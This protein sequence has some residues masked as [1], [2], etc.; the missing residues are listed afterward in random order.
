MTTNKSETRLSNPLNLISKIASMIVILV[1][2]VVFVGW[3]FD[4]I[5]LK[6]V[7]PGFVT[8]KANTAIGFLFAGIALWLLND[9]Q[10]SQQWRIAADIF[11][12]IVT[13]L[14]G[15]TL[16]QYI[17]GLDFGIDQLFF[18]EASGAIGTS[19]PGRMAPNTALSFIFIGIALFLMNKKTVRLFLFSHF[20]VLTAVLITWTAL[21][22]YFYGIEESYGIPGYTRMALHTSLTFIVLS[23]GILFTRTNRGLIAVLI[24]ENTGSILMRRLLLAA[25]LLPVI[26][27]W[28]RWKGEIEGIYSTAV[29]M[30][31][32]VLATTVVLSITI[33]WVAVAF[34]RADKER[35]RA[36]EEL[37]KNRDQLEDIV[38]E[39]TSELSDAYSKMININ[40]ALKTLSECN[41]I[42]V[43]SK[44]EKELLDEICKVIVE[45]G[46]Y[47]MAW[48]GFA[49]NDE[50]KSVRVAAKAGFEKGYLEKINVTWKDTERGRGPTGTAIRTGKTVHVQDITNNE[51]FRPWRDIAIKHG[52]ASSIALPL[53][54]NG[55]IGGALSIYSKEP[56]AFNEDE[57]KLLE[58]LAM[59]LAYGIKALCAKIEKEKAVQQLAESEIKQHIIVKSI[60]DTLITIN[61]NGVIQSVNERGKEMFGYSAEELI[62]QP[63]ELLIPD[64]FREVHHKHRDKYQLDPKMREMGADLDLYAKRRNGTEFPVDVSLSPFSINQDHFVLCVVRDVTERKRLETRERNQS[65]IL[66]LI[67]KGTPLPA[68]LELIVKSIEQEDPSWL[69]SI[70]LL[71][72]EG[73]HLLHGAAPSLPDFYNQAI[74]GLAIGDGVGSCG[75]AAYAKKQVIVEDIFIHPYWIPFREL[76]QKANLHSCWSEPIIST[77]GKVLGT[78]AI[79]HREPKSPTQED[80]QRINFAAYFASI[81]IERKQTEEELIKAKEKAEEMNKLKSYFLSNM[82]HELR[83]PLISVLG[84]AEFLQSELTNPE[85]IE[86]ASQIMEGGKRLNQTLNSLLEFSKLEAESETAPLMPHNLADEVL[87]SVEPFKTAAKKKGIH[88]EAKI[89]DDKLSANINSELFQKALFHLITNAIKFTKAGSIT[90]ELSLAYDENKHWAVVKVIDTGIGIPEKLYD[91]LFAG[92][93]QASEGFSRYYEGVGLGLPLTNKIVNLLNGKISVK[94]KVGKGSEFSIWLPAIPDKKELIQEVKV[95]SDAL[96]EE[97]LSIKK[98][99]PAILLVEDNESNRMVIQ[100]FLKDRYDITEAVDGIFAITLAAKMKFDMILVDINLGE[101]VN[102]V[103]TMRQMRKIPGYVQIPIIAV[104]AY[105]MAGDSERFLREG[106]DGYITKPFSKKNLLEII[107]LKIGQAN[108]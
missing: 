101:G 33:L 46:G 4:I 98:T 7:Y 51:S 32:M 18:K 39:R 20:F 41:Q 29:G 25:I 100:L 55:G 47:R 60:P 16:C 83:T 21:L 79:Y 93:R 13:L 96:I 15:L 12:M 52:Y 64:R 48:I 63:I 3:I 81:A 108:K 104:T 82:S 34:N 36:E 89:V 103:E 53:E 87:K 43:R 70:L 69:C 84:F 68:I 71:D 91:K 10:S 54:F 85:H 76:A 57:I 56:N 31:I 78:F 72:E 24:S 92:F 14:G 90:V 107:Q 61:R 49:E 66:E 27:G 62:D 88:L 59:D 97:P 45:H 99:L 75:T 30:I 95:K 94:S 11:S 102:G 106:F 67:V 1:G 73:K 17:F 19:Q 35:K 8:M 37:K 5:I 44:D 77:D 80:F 22:G 6:S 28:L 9:E 42:L 23:V 58:E 74:H 50:N 38:A 65:R 40:R 2:C 26:I 86:M 105:A